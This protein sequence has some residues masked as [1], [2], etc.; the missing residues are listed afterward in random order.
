VEEAI[1]EVC[2]IRRWQLWTCNIRTN[3]VHTV[4]TA[5]CDP[6]STLSVSRENRCRKRCTVHLQNRGA[7][8]TGSKSRELLDREL[9]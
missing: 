3:H 4:V 7:L 8:A 5:T 9:I 2:R 6:L 1:K